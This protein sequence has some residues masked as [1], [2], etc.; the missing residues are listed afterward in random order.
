MKN[1]ILYTVNN[2]LCTGCGLCE[3]VCPTHSIEIYRI[4]GEWRPHL[5]KVTCLGDKCGRCLKICPGVGC[6]L[7]KL[8]ADLFQVKTIQYDKYIGFYNSLYTGY[9]LDNEIRTHSA[10]GGIVSQ[11]LIYLLA[12]KVID[13][14][15]KTQ[16]EVTLKD[17]STIITS[18][19][20]TYPTANKKVI[21]NIVKT[22]INNK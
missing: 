14:L 18:V 1:N 4:N 17:M 3:D 7:T 20:M 16:K 8:P 13:G 5:N 21:S 15:L 19:R 11:F 6:D 22:L 9:S 10:S 12:K 2:S